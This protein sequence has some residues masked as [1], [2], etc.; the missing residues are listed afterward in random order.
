MYTIRMTAEA[1]RGLRSI[2]S[3]IVGYVA[4]AIQALASE[5]RPA[6]CQELG[7]NYYRIAEWGYVIEYVIEYEIVERDVFIRIVFIG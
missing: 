4:A 2:P 5:P 3:G 6:G 7:G 1:M